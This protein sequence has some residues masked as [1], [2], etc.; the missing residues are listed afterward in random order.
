MNDNNVLNDYQF[1]FRKHST[2][3][4]IITFV[5]RVEK[6]LDTGKVVFGLFLD[7]KKAFDTVI[8]LSYSINVKTMVYK[9]LF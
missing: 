1:G 3:H 6:A 5:E 8:I 9:E 7:P 2:S 4:V